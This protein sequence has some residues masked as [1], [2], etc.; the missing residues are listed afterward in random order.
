MAVCIPFFN[1]AEHIKLYLNLSLI[2]QT[3]TNA[4]IPWFVGEVTFIEKPWFF[5]EAHNIFRFRTQSYMFYKEQILNKMIQLLPSEFTKICILD[6][7][8]LFQNLEWY[9]KTSEILNTW[10]ACQPFSDVQMLNSKY[11]M[12]S[13]H[14]SAAKSKDLRGHPG[15]AWAFDRAWIQQ[16]PLP[17]FAVIGSGDMAFLRAMGSKICMPETMFQSLLP[18]ID[19]YVKITPA[20]PITHVD[21]YI[22]HLYHGSRTNRKYSSRYP[23]ITSIIDTVGG[24]EKALMRNSE[25][26]YEWVPEIRDQVNE[27]VLKYFVERDED[28]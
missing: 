11:R 28:D 22:Y 27:I 25:G 15:F 13:Q 14:S 3:L 2:L 9:Q 10:K 26:L 5:S 21:G 1:P 20:I 7:D 16:H 23:L 24:L 18:L 6:C 8:V 19:E 17:E 12:E 4:K